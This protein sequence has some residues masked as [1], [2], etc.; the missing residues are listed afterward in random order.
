M[1]VTKRVLIRVTTRVIIICGLHAV[2][3]L[4]RSYTF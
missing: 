1:R 2:F 3:R 4:A